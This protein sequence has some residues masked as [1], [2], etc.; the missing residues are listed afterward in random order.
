[1][2]KTWP[3]TENGT[4]TGSVEICTV[5]PISW[6]WK[7]GAKAAA[8]TISSIRKVAIFTEIN[9]FPRVQYRRKT[10]RNHG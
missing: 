2:R 5:T 8:K 7:T 10:L 6:A 3:S 9:L 1:V 4:F